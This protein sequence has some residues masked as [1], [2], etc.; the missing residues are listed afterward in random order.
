M[1]KTTRFMALTL[2]FCSIAIGLFLSCQKT[3]N[4]KQNMVSFDRVNAF[5]KILKPVNAKTDMISENLKSNNVKTNF[6]N[7]LA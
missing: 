4:S 5:F 6:I 2:L 3:T 7:R 1:K